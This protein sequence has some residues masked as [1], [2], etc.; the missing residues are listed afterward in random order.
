MTVLRVNVS[1]SSVTCN[2]DPPMYTTVCP[3]TNSY[4]P[5]HSHQIFPHSSE[6][7]VGHT[8]D[9][10]TGISSVPVLSRSP[11]ESIQVSPNLFPTTDAL[12]HLQC[13]FRLA[14]FNVQ[15]LMHRG[16][17]KRLAHALETVAICVCCIQ[18]T[19]A[20]LSD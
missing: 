17:R 6:T 1:C 15:T 19:P 3:S 13:L 2:S 12:L 14:A 11:P 5:S 4:Y 20:I 10:T 18:K 7:A 9:S 16:Q 8:S